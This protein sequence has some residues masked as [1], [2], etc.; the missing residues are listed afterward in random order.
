MFVSDHFIQHYQASRFHTVVTAPR[1]QRKHHDASRLVLEQQSLEHTCYCTRISAVTKI[2]PNIHSAHAQ[3]MNPLPPNHYKCCCPQR[4]MTPGSAV[5]AP[6]CTPSPSSPW[7]RT[8][9]F[10]IGSVSASLTPKPIAS[11]HFIR[12]I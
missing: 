10:S 9:P 5:T 2:K 4:F 8:N 12:D 6:Y 3:P 7:T 11:G 1:G